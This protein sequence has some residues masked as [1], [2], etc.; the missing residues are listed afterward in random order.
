MSKNKRNQ[1]IK[2][3]NRRNNYVSIKNFLWISR[4]FFQKKDR[5]MSNFLDKG[6]ENE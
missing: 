3:K 2:D 6:M 5:I 1:G 4:V